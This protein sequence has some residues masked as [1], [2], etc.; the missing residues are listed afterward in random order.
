[1]GKPQVTQGSSPALWVVL[2]VAGAVLLT[3]VD[4]QLNVETA[5]GSSFVDVEM[6]LGALMVIVLGATASRMQAPSPPKK[7][8]PEE[9]CCDDMSEVSEEAESQTS[10]EQLREPCARWNAGACKARPGQCRFAHFCTLCNNK[11]ARHRAL[12]RF[13]P[14]S[15][16]R[17]VMQTSH[18][19]RVLAAVE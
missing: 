14:H 8:L 3:V 12:S 10:Q 16:K 1:M 6:A 17:K 18:V 13:C 7:I 5:E 2:A 4:H 15:E 19:S 11:K 9:E